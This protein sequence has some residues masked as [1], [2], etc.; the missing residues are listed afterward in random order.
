MFVR[1]RNMGLASL[2]PTGIFGYYLLSFVYDFFWNMYSNSWNFDRP[3]DI[4]QSPY[5]ELVVGSVITLILLSVVIA[6]FMS[7]VYYFIAAQKKSEL[8]LRR[9]HNL[10]IYCWIFVIICLIPVTGAIV[11]E[12]MNMVL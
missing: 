1:Y 4:S 5:T 12:L 3:F 6:S 10:R 7:S 2:I 11:Y 9:G 8:W